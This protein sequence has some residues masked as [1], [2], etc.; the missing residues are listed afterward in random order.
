MEP[1]EVLSPQSRWPGPAAWA[2][3]SCAS[4]LVTWTRT[5]PK[6]SP[7]VKIV[8]RADD[9]HT[10]QVLPRRWPVERTLAWISRRRRTVCDHERLPEHHETIIYWTVILTM[11]RRL[12]R[13]SPSRPQAI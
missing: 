8:L 6:P 9:L 3:G 10:F 11:S 7:Q 2:D 13:G 5:Q 12:T 4:K 1:A